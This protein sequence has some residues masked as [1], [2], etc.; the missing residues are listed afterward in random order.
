MNKVACTLLSL[1]AVAFALGVGTATAQ[2][3]NYDVGY[4]AN[5]NASGAPSAQLRLT[6]DGNNP[7]YLCAAIFSV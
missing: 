5:A 3:Y 7:P 1:L 4:F 2:D 6:N